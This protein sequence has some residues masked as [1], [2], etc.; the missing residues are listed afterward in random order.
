MK[1]FLLSLL[2]FATAVLTAAPDPFNPKYGWMDALVEKNFLPFEKGISRKS[3][4]KTQNAHPWIVRIKVKNNRVTQAKGEKGAAYKMIQHL[5]ETYGLPDLDILYFQQ[6][7]IAGPLAGDAPVLCSSKKKN[8]IQ[9]IY[10]ADWLSHMPNPQW[11]DIAHRIN[12]TLEHLNWEDKK[13][14]LIWRG[15][16]TDGY[17]TPKNWF[18]Q[19]RGKLCYLSLL[20]PDLIDARFVWACAYT[21]S[22]PHNVWNAVP[23]GQFMTHEEQV[24]YKY[25]I[26]VDGL[27]TTYPGD[28]WRLLSDSVV[29]MHESEYGHWF[30][31]ALIPW[32]HYVPVKSDLSDLVEKL[33]MMRQQPL[34]G[35]QLAANAREFAQNY[36]MSEHIAIYCYKTLLK[37]ASLQKFNP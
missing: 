13:D 4:D 35:R 33:E 29:F 37:Y 16:T 14:Q 24:G 32:I 31:E 26:I 9:G 36:L 27:F 5:A 17:Y 34:L 12:E 18:Q 20:Y 28:R 8:V 11:D 15:A 1:K 3:I 7:G 21:S 10:F 6:D 19:R 23:Q 25:Q 30:Y 2:V 22:N